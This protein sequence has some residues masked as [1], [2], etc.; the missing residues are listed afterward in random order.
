M[1]HEWHQKVAGYFEYV[2]NA[3]MIVIGVVIFGFLLR[4]LLNLA[5]MLWMTDIAGHFTEL[6]EEILVVFL[7]FEFLSLVREYFIKDAHIS[8]GNFLYIGVTALIRAML[9]YHDQTDK[10]LML[11]AAIFLLV[12]AQAIYRCFRPKMDN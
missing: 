2:L 11:A 8:T 12:V 9:V 3:V 10:T 1:K 4:E 7:F 6:A 5:Q